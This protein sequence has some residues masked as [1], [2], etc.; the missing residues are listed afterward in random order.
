M[1]RLESVFSEYE[2][3]NSSIKL[4]GSE[5]FVKLGCVGAASEE[6]VVVVV[7]KK[8]EGQVAKSVSKGATNG[9]LNL[10]LHMRHDLYVEAFGMI[11]EGLK[12]GVYA[13][14]KNSRHKEFCFVAEVFDE[15]GNSKLI[16][17]PRCVMASAPKG[18]ITNGAEEVAEIEIDINLFAD[19]DGNVKYEA[20][21]SE[22]ED[23]EGENI[24]NTWLTAFST[25][26]VK[27]EQ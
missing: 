10:T 1:A 23:A 8:C 11:Q 2:I 12:D 18:T 13:Y 27:K 7:Q 6:L 9:T 19:E 14:G 24:V 15:D 5:N 26:L 16:A 17:Y 20:I 3:K 21:V 4:V 22:M 25:E